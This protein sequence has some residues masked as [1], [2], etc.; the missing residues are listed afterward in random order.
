MKRESGQATYRAEKAKR[1]PNVP[2]DELM[3]DA[4]AA[5]DRMMDEGR[6]ARKGGRPKK[7]KDE[8][9]AGGK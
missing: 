4:K 6:A 5:F 9:A 7:A 1:G 3:A 8:P 2:H